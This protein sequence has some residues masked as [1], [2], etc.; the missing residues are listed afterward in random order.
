MLDEQVIQCGELRVDFRRCDDRYGHIIERLVHDAWRAVYESREGN[1][2]DQWP[3]SPVLQSLHIEQGSKGSVAFLLGMAGT[4][5]WS[6]SVEPVPNRD[7]LQ[8]D[9]AC[10]VNQA[11]QRLGSSYRVL[12]PEAS[13]CIEVIALPIEAV[14]AIQRAASETEWTAV[15]IIADQ[16]WPCTIRWRY[17]ISVIG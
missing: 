7:A 15:P 13:R 6:A 9:I 1:S 5:H 4:S 11:P 3:P 16:E 14:T 12:D 10:R 2:A 17:T 8:F